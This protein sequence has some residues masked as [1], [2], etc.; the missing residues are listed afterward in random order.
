[1]TDEGDQ[2]T[3]RV[4]YES[5]HKPIRALYNGILGGKEMSGT[6]I[7]PESIRFGAK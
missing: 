2:P 3:Y 5:E 7:V 4:D 6:W 1:M